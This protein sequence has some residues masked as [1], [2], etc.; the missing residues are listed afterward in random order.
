MASSTDSTRNSR[1][2]KTPRPA[3]GPDDSEDGHRLRLLV[4]NWQDRHNP[5]AGGAEIQLH[6]TFGRLADRGHRITLLVSGWEGA[7]ARTEVDGMRVLRTGRRHTFPPHAWVTYRRELRDQPFDLVVED[8]NKLPL[9]TPL[10]GDAPVV[11]QVPHL[12]G[13]VAFRQAP[14]PVAAAVWA[15]ERVMPWVYRGSRV[16]AAS[17]STARD[18]VERGF[19]RRRIRVIH[20]GVDHGFFHP[21]PTVGRFEEPT[22]VYVG[23]LKRYKELDMVLEGMVRLRERGEAP[24][25]LVA[26]KGD[27]RPRLERRVRELDLGHE[28]RFLGFVSDERKRELLRR[29]WC[30]V[31]P[32]P[33]EGWGITNVEAAACGTPTVASDSPGLRESVAEGESGLLVPHADPDAWASALARVLD[34]DEL[35]R[36]LGEGA[37]EHARKFSWR[38]AADETESDL[39]RIARTRGERDEDHRRGATL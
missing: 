11:L 34:D 19:R 12:F 38:R 26:G 35:R 25:L 28:V 16:H 23:R 18:L 9:L 20:N 6:E 1:N 10:W 4:V 15:G 7:A 5:R 3:E 37:R 27:D 24:R 30:T 32:S 14:W 36:R 31:Y 22:L 21:D 17:E 39:I 8:V 29:A 33:K 2:R 13:S